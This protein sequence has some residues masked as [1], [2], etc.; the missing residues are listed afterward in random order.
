M[1]RSQALRLHTTILS[2]PLFLTSL[3]SQSPVENHPE[4]G[5]LERKML[6]DV[7]KLAFGHS[8]MKGFTV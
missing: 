2:I 3:A 8:K 6:W 7:F 4:K 1:A 5:R